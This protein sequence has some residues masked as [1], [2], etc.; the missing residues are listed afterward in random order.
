M[1]TQIV[2]DGRNIGRVWLV[3]FNTSGVRVSLVSSEWWR[4]RTP[5]GRETETMSYQSAVEWLKTE[6]KAIAIDLPYL[7]EMTLSPQASE[8]AREMVNNCGPQWVTDILNRRRP[9]EDSRDQ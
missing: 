1:D 2:H 4:A 9:E 8:R 6:H 5:D 3:G 7:G